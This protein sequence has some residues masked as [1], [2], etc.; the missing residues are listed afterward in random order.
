M[1]E[2]MAW[3]VVDWMVPMDLSLLVPENY[4]KTRIEETDNNNN[5]SKQKDAMIQKLKKRSWI[6]IMNV[7]RHRINVRDQ[8]LAMY[9]LEVPIFLPGRVTSHM[10]DII[11]TRLPISA[12][13]PQVNI[14]S[15]NQPV[16]ESS[17]N[18]VY[19]TKT[20]VKSILYILKTL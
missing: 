16:E 4:R 20:V 7:T 13:L 18:L 11:A 8:Q 15:A 10:K 17:S 5:K 3:H 14:V 19:Y 12:P 1:M 6:T 9:S 2:L